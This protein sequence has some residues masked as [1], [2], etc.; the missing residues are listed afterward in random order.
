MATG[1][2]LSHVDL[3][4]LEATLALARLADGAVQP[5]PLVGSI[6]VDSHTGAIVGRGHHVTFGGRHAEPVALAEARSRAQGATL[7]C[8]LEPCGY[9]APQKRQPACTSA[10]IAAGVQRVVAGQIDPHPQ[11]RGR[12]L[13][14]LRDAGLEVELAPDPRPFWRFNAVFTTTMALR[15]PL[16]HVVT[17]AGDG[18]DASAPWHDAELPPAALAGAPQA[19][20]IL[21]R[22]ADPDELLLPPGWQVDV[23]D[24]RPTEAWIRALEAA[25]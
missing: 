9:E 22:C 21:T 13:Q 2:G 3:E 24:G 12:G 8:N 16:L 14:R 20:S 23:L 4:R 11:V 6:L 5:D 1:V 25:S 7:Y 15:R 10:I 17:A 18:R 19:H